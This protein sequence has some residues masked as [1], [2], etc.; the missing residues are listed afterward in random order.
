VAS[1]PIH[2]SYYIS[3]RWREWIRAGGAGI[4]RIAS[5]EAQ[6]REKLVRERRRLG[7]VHA[8]EKD[9]FLDQIVEFSFRAEAI[10]R[11]SSWEARISGHDDGGWDAGMERL[12]CCLC[13]KYIQSHSTWD[14]CRTTRSLAC[15]TLKPRSLQAMRTAGA[16]RSERKAGNCIRSGDWSG[17][18]NSREP[19]KKLGGGGQEKGREGQRGASYVA[20][21]NRIIEIQSPK[22]GRISG[23]VRLAFW[24]PS[25]HP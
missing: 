21:R 2:V 6:S 12:S 19:P 18:P 24:S 4:R 10:L 15:N 8:E 23:S 13:Y 17:E 9:I 7:S 3:V 20:C 16:A 11:Q 14:A 5:I 1:R 25:C 22:R